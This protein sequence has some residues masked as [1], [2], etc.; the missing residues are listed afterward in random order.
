MGETGSSVV[1][2]EEER[3]T[4]QEIMNI[5]FGKATADLADLIDIYI[6]LTVPNI[7]VLDTSALWTYIREE[8]TGYADISTVQQRFWGQFKGFA[9]LVFP[10][11]S[12]KELIGLL[13]DEDDHSFASDP[14]DELEKGTLMEIGNILIGACVGKIAELLQDEVTYSPPVIHSSGGTQDILPKAAAD[15]FDLTIAMRT[16]FTFE[17]KDIAGFLFIVTSHE[18]MLWLKKALSDFLAQYQ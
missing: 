6:N 14:I 8:I 3:D 12:G 11:G 7:R 13:M 15:S 1:F 2:T 9:L 16:S 17:A 10:A 4:I 18:S 5:A